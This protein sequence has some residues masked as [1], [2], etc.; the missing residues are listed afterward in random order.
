MF[1]PRVVQPLL[2]S[3]HPAVRKFAVRTK[4]LVPIL[5][6]F[7]LLSPLLPSPFSSLLPSSP[8]SPQSVV[9]LLKKRIQV[10]KEHSKAVQKLSSSLTEDS[11]FKH[12]KFEGLADHLKHFLTVSLPSFSHLLL[13]LSPPSSFP[14]PSSPSLPPL[15]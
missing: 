10:D 8:I 5:L 7:P 12:M 14:F 9:V 6:P 3:L 2:R 1:V 15:V 13:F 11:Q 4:L